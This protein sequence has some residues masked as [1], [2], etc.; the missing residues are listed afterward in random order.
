LYCRNCQR[1]TD[2]SQ[3]GVDLCC[4]EC[5]WIT[6]TREHENPTDRMALA[7]M[8]DDETAAW[9]EQHG[10]SV[11]WAVSEDMHHIIKFTPPD[12]RAALAA[13]PA[14]EPVAYT[15][16]A[17]YW[18]KLESVPVELR[19][20]VRPLYA[21]PQP[22]ISPPVEPDDD[23]AVMAAYR[24][25][26]AAGFAAGIVAQQPPAAQADDPI[27]RE[28][29]VILRELHD[30]LDEMS[31]KR[32]KEAGLTGYV[33]R[34]EK[35]QV[36]MQSALRAQP[37]A[38]Q[39][40]TGAVRIYPPEL[41]KMP[42]GAVFDAMSREDLWDWAC[43]TGW[44]CAQPQAA[45]KVVAALPGWVHYVIETAMYGAAPSI[46]D[47]LAKIR[48]MLAAKLPALDG[49]EIKRALMAIQP[50]AEID[51]QLVIR[52]ESV[53]DIIDGRLSLAA[54]TQADPGAEGGCKSCGSNV[55][56]AHSPDCAT[57]DESN[58]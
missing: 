50:I 32:K 24:Q 45:E 28:A 2:H 57:R 33:E 3:R 37:Q 29:F 18:A 19:G 56:G 53:R 1:F 44:R 35:L 36:R 27:R 5:H 55:T 26:R 40:D 38:A 14:A 11:A 10:A 22:P 51:G 16:A 31:V 49:E 6:A 15:F 21:S 12:L 4:D 23:Y 41:P 43:L 54:T 25:G 30:R 42:K 39:A 20:R 8:N 47:G 17:S 58:E 7:A 46:A 52:R 13:A 34:I 9:A 48:S